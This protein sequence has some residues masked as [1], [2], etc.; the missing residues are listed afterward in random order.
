MAHVRINMAEV[1]SREEMQ[2]TIEP[3]QK[4]MK[5]IFSEM[6]LFIA[7]ETSETSMLGVS[8]YD[9]KDAADRAVANST[10][11]LEDKEIEVPKKLGTSTFEPINSKSSSGFFSS[12]ACYFSLKSMCFRK[13]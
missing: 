10:K 7:V 4:N 2:R 6:R 12:T 9:D 1:E 3:L 8:V 13:R 11:Y 5:S